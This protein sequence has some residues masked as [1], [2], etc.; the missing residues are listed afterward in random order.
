MKVE[1]EANVENMVGIRFVRMCMEG[2]IRGKCIKHGGFPL[3]TECDTPQLYME[4]GIR[5]KCSKHGGYPLTQ[6]VIFL[7]TT[8]KAEFEENVVSMVGAQNVIHL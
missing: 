2:G 5:G 8:K 3:C 6:D 4:G 1:S 7:K